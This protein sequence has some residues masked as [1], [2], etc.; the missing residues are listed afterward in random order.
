MSDEN[1]NEKAPLLSERAMRGLAD[2]FAF[3][4][5][6]GFLA[7]TT[8]LVVWGLVWLFELLFG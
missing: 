7:A 6:G 3:V 1:E 4:I 8:M 5:V 2:Y